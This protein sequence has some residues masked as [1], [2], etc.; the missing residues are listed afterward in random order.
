VPLEHKARQVGNVCILDSDGDLGSDIDL[1]WAVH[2]HIEKGQSNLILNLK[3]VQWLSSEGIGQMVAS[4]KRARS[5]GGEL[6]ILHPSGQVA[7]ILEMVGLN[8]IFEIY[9]NETEA[10]ASFRSSGK[11]DEPA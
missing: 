10:I 8:K 1:S 4:M 3:G 5:K 9:H 2:E 7:Q 6:K 11:P